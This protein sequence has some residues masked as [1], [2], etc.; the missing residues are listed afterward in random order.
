M[1]DTLFSQSP[2]FQLVAFSVH[3][4]AVLLIVLLSMRLVA[5]M[6]PDLQSVVPVGPSFASVTSIFALLLAFHAAAIW[7]HRQTAERAFTQVQS[8]VYRFD[9]LVSSHG[10]NAPE[11]STALRNYVHSAVK[12]EWLGMGNKMM[13]DSTEAAFLALEITLLK[14]QVLQP[15]AVQTQLTSLL[16]EIARSRSDRLWVGGHHTDGYIWLSV[17]LIGALSHFAIAAI[18]LDRPKAGRF[19]LTLFAVTTT[20]AY[21]SLGVMSDPYRDVDNLNPEV[22]LKFRIDRTELPEP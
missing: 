14:F 13:S 8:A 6:C 22:L 12:E 1:L 20:I 15:P 2:L 7:S 11:V 10:L 3:G 18:H 4:A 17:L 9:D 16:N 19:M 5:R 21:W